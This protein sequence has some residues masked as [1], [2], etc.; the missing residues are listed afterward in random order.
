MNLEIFHAAADARSYPFTNANLL[1]NTVRN[2]GTNGDVR[3]TKQLL[4]IATP[5]HVFLDCGGSSIY[6]AEKKGKEILCDPSRPVY[7]K[8]KTKL[9]LT[10]EHVI[11]AAIEFKPRTIVALDWPLQPKKTKAEQEKEFQRKLL[12]NL[13]WAKETAKLWQKHCPDAS[14]MIPIQAKTLDQ[15]E[16]FMEG[17][18][19]LK[20]TGVSLP[21]RNVN[22]KLL[23]QFLIRLHQL[24]IPWV[25]I[26]GTTSFAYLGIAAYFARQN[27]FKLVSLD[28]SSWKASGNSS[29]YMSPHNLLSCKINEHTFIPEKLRNDCLCPFCRNKTFQDIS[30]DMF[31][32]RSLLL[33]CHNAWVTEQV[34]RDLYRNARSLSQLKHYMMNKKSPNQKE[35]RRAIDALSL[36]ENMKI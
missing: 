29:S 7:K 15:F 6:Y 22:P 14:F 23:V 28:S 34:A 35:V 27:L 25:H 3:E 33:S 13:A 8:S 4:E 9:N 20:F 1:I 21:Y 36:V 26:L 31:G 18:S 2:A 17:L 5:R 32:S 19:G 11:K 12:I 30:F 10:P 24:K 16:E